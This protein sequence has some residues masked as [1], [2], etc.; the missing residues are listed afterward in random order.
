MS[1]ILNYIN[2]SS[3]PELNKVNNAFNNNIIVELRFNVFYINFII[4]LL[5][6]NL[7]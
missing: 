5:K 2:V 7:Y 3:A 6:L 1:S 4:I